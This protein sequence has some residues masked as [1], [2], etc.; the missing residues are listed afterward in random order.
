M[1][2]RW[3]R[4]ARASEHTYGRCAAVQCAV[5]IG[6]RHES[7]NSGTVPLQVWLAIGL[8]AREAGPGGNGQH[9]ERWLD[10]QIDFGRIIDQRQVHLA[11]SAIHDTSATTLPRCMTF[12]YA[13]EN[14][15]SVQV[16]FDRV[17]RLLHVAPLRAVRWGTESAQLLGCG[18]RDKQVRC[19]QTVEFSPACA[20]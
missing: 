3:G 20:V 11:C 5:G 1:R 19:V 15:P 7:R 14:R 4:P 13:N 9:D 17:S 2:R 16:R 10:E 8:A 12:T 18:R 6:K